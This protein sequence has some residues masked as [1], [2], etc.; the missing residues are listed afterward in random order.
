[1]SATALNMAL[2]AS[3]YEGTLFPEPQDLADASRGVEEGAEEGK[4]DE[5]KEEEKIRQ[6]LAELAT[7]LG[8][9]R[10]LRK[11]RKALG[12]KV[13][14]HTTKYP[15]LLC[16]PTRLRRKPMALIIG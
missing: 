16:G 11:V 10:L 8:D 5:D 4:R 9:V 14:T 12:L 7:A 6:T 2:K 15:P 3:G 1:M 13:R